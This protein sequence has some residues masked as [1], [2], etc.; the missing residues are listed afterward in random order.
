MSFNFSRYYK[1][2]IVRNDSAEYVNQLSGRQ[3]S[4][5]DHFDTAKMGWPSDEMLGILII[6]NEYW[7]TGMRFYKLADK[8]YGDPSL[9]W[10]LPWFN[11]KPLESD[12]LPGD[13][14]MIPRPLDILLDF[15]R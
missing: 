6:D 13:L 14:I 2:N 3:V 10:I 8:Y 1:R 12:F 9:W 5:I 11:Q 7:A 4:Y 15:F